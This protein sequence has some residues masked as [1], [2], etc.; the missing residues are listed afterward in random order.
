MAGD[1][2][3][4]SAT[5]DRSSH[6]LVDQSALPETKMRL[7]ADLEI[8]LALG[9]A[10]FKANA[11]ARGSDPVRIEGTLP[12]KLEKRDA[13]Y[14]LS[15]DGPLSATL[16]F[17]AIFL[18]KLPTYLS[19]GLLTRGILSGNLNVADSVQHPLV[20][21]SVNLVDGQF[22][23]GP[24]VS[25]GL[26][27]KG[28]NAALDYLHLGKASY[29]TYIFDSLVPSF[30]FAVRGD[31]DFSSL[32]EIKLKILPA[33][34]VF[35]SSP[36]MGA[37]DC[38]SSIEF[39]PILMLSSQPIQA[40]ELGGSLFTRSFAI[41]FPSIDGVRPSDVFPLCHDNTSSGKTLLLT[42]SSQ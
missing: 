28:R 30:E 19:R 22:L 15:S 40:I 32:D 41:S 20:T 10:N 27:F 21:G 16:N 8:Q 7:T 31:I 29:F 37:G 26:T 23:R 24:A 1:I 11:I 36:A 25:T 4:R 38:V 9:M 35:P 17:P 18:A 42:L 13:E 14:A 39:H 33:T 3:G 34:H 6:Y 12:L 2:F 5:V